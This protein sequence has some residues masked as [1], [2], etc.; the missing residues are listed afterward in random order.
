MAETPPNRP[1]S[2]GAELSRK[3]FLGVAARVLAGGAAVAAVGVVNPV[4][5]RE[6]GPDKPGGSSPAARLEENRASQNIPEYDRQPTIVTAKDL[7]DASGVNL[8]PLPN[9]RVP[10]ST[11]D[12]QI[13]PDTGRYTD[14]VLASPEDHALQDFADVFRLPNGQGVIRFSFDPKAIVGV[15]ADTWTFISEQSTRRPGDTG[16]VNVSTGQLQRIVQAQLAQKDPGDPDRRVEVLLHTGGLD[17]YGA[18]NAL[19]LPSNT[20]IVNDDK[21]SRGDV[22][23]NVSMSPKIGS[24]MVMGAGGRL[25][26]GD[27]LVTGIGRST[28]FAFS[29]GKSG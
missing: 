19:R 1:N 26:I 6:I 17:S 12:R 8:E 20:L 29:G 2:V 7:K 16:E 10:G 28:R 18:E 3:D 25:D 9:S 4:S 14:R 5:A 22:K 24:V 13:D 11:I 15:A 21:I 23:P 27:P